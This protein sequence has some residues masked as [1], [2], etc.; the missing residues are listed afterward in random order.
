M[1]ETV[2]TP[3]GEHNGLW[4]IEESTGKEM[5]AVWKRKIHSI[6]VVFLGS[7]YGKLER[8]LGRRIRDCDMSLPFRCQKGKITT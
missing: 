1:A 3:L 4:R 8:S 5:I 6:I 2:G 7:S